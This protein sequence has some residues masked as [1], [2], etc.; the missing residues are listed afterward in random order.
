MLM[1]P[2]VGLTRPRLRACGLI[3]S[4]FD[5]SM[6]VALDGSPRVVEGFLTREPLLLNLVLPH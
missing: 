5:K 4:G 6:V 3:A 2:Y 1:S